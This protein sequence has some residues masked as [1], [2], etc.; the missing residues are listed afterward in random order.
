MGARSRLPVQARK[1]YSMEM[2]IVPDH[3][4]LTQ[5]YQTLVHRRKAS[6]RFCCQLTRAGRPATSS[7]FRKNS[8][9]PENPKKNINKAEHQIMS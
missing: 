4:P 2:R 5:A 9:H 1:F 8:P 3:P 6:A 7:A